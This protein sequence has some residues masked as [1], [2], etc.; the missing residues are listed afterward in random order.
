[1]RPVDLAL[2]LLPTLLLMAVDKMKSKL[3]DELDNQCK[4]VDHLLTDCIQFMSSIQR[5]PL[6][7]ELPK[8]QVILYYMDGFN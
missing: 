4:C 6:L 5:H 7:N 8:L 2:Q 3:K 1:M